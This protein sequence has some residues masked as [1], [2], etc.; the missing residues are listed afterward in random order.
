MSTGGLVFNLE[1]KMSETLLH[2]EL[3]CK[4]L[5]KDDRDR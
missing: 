2:Y 3:Q 4:E 1:E 5:K